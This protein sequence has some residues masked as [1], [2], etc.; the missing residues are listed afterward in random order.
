MNAAVSGVTRIADGCNLTGAPLRIVW[1][2]IERAGA[3]A[4]SF[5]GRGGRH[6]QELSTSWDGNKRWRTGGTGGAYVDGERVGPLGGTLV[7]ASVPGSTTD[8]G[9]GARAEEMLL[10]PQDELVHVLFGGRRSRCGR[11]RERRDADERFAIQPAV[12]HH[13]AEGARGGE[14]R[15]SSDDRS[16][17][18][19]G[20]SAGRERQLRAWVCGCLFLF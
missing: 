7:S 8:A 14:A 3:P 12:E 4:Y 20:S 10:P 5:A 6:V 13:R 1:P 17:V 2:V 16:A 11:R 18:N 9:D 15:P 19:H